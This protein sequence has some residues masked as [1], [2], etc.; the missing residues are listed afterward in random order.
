M[1]ALTYQVLTFKS[2]AG[3]FRTNRF[4]PLN[5]ELKNPIRHLLAFVG[6]RH[7]VHVSRIRVNI[8]NFYM[9]LALR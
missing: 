3:S 7:I 4:N 1:V 8:Q 9:V 2:L 5:A 6:A